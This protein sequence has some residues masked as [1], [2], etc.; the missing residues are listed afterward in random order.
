MK[1]LL[2]AIALL[3]VGC[4]SK[5]NHF[6]TDP[7]VKKAEEAAAAKAKAEADSLLKVQ[8]VLAAA[9][10]DSIVT[11][12]IDKLEKACGVKSDEFNGT[13]FYTPK[14]VS[15]YIDVNQVYAYLC[16]SDGQYWPRLVFQYS[17][18]NW[19]FISSVKILTDNGTRELTGEWKTDNGSGKIWEWQ[20]FNATS[21]EDA[22]F[23]LN[24]MAKSKTIKIRFVGNQYH[25]D[26][27]LS[28]K[29]LASIRLIFEAYEE[30]RRL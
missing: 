12:T 6:Y 19:L 16:E 2:F 1:Y 28:S 17:A 20:D 22:Y 27:T 3:L 26:R 9:R 25:H 30:L 15:K 10:K 8:A 18:D 14:T 21:G 4:D 13:R 7:A 23:V 29:E 11:T 5:K 24:D